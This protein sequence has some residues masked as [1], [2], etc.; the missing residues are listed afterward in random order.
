[1]EVVE[2]KYHDLKH[3]IGLLRSEITSEEKLGYLQGLED[4]IRAM[5]AQ[6]KT[7]NQVLDT[8]LTARSLQCQHLGITLTVVA[9][10]RALDF[11]EP[12]DLAALFGNA[13]DNAVESVQKIE[14]VTRRL[15]HLSIARQK[16]FALIRFEN[17]YTGELSYVDGEL[18]TTKKDVKYHGYGLKSMRNISEKYGGSCTVKTREGWFE[19]HILLPIP[20]Q[21]AQA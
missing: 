18:H 3:Q 8:L 4:E 1:M 9:D 19:L 15:I 6:N 21:K 20:A 13:L 7:G 17:C 10:G 12:M 14:D 11:M 5:E 16:G 2:E